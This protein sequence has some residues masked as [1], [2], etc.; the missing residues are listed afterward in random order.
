MQDV[1]ITN[2]RLFNWTN[3]VAFSQGMPGDGVCKLTLTSNSFYRLTNGVC[4][5]VA[6]PKT[7]TGEIIARQNLFLNCKEVAHGPAGAL[8]G[9]LVT[10]NARDQNSTESAGLTFGTSV[11][12]GPIETDSKKDDNFLKAPKTGPLSEFGPRK[13]ILGAQ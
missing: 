2:C 5:D 7:V 9:L 12:N 8:A 6:M 13:V 10:D 4:C 11:V 1:L 3:G